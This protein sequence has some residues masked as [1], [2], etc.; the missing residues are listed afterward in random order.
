M[1]GLFFNNSIL[2]ANA[3]TFDHAYQ[4][5]YKQMNLVISQNILTDMGLLVPVAVNCLFACELFLKSM[6]PEGTRGHNLVELL[7]V[8]DDVSRNAIIESSIKLM[9]QHKPDYSKDNFY[10]DI[11]CNS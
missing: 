8:L 2:L 3:Y 5:L 10:S 7:N 6:L 4:I 11:N 1:C 9:Q